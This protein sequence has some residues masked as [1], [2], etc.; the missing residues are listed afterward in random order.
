M[1][2]RMRGQAGECLLCRRLLDGASLDLGLL[3]P[4]NRFGLDAAIPLPRARLHVAACPAC[5][6]IQLDPLPAV[7]D[8]VP[9]LPWIRYNEPD[10][11]LATVVSEIAARVDRARMPVV[12]FGPF[13]PPLL[14]RLAA[15]GFTASYI[16]L[17][18]RARAS[19]P[20]GTFPY[21]ETVQ[22][23][24]A[25]VPLQP[26]ANAEG[27]PRIVVCRYLLE[28][29]HAPRAALERMAALAGP[30]G[31]LVI[32]VPDSTK[33]LAARDYS[34]FWEEHTCYFTPGTLRLMLTGAGLGI[35]ALLSFPGQLDDALVAWV[36][37][38]G[39]ATDGGE[40]GGDAGDGRRLVGGLAAG[41]GAL[42]LAYHD[43]L[44]AL[45]A[46]GRKAALF[47][48]G[49]QAI[50]FLNALELTD[51]FAYVVDDDPTKQG[52]LVP[53]TGTRIVSSAAMLADSAVDVCLV[54][55]SPHV[56][57]RI[58]ARCAL[59]LDRGGKLASI[60]PGSELGTLLD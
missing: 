12:G 26:A 54:A 3:P 31:R 30:D 6:L 41:L 48:A 33:F 37:P 27:T 53:G 4:C 56:E 23:T 20:H 10:H 18:Q 35:D 47:G 5:G 59:L 52:Y 60:Y 39:R 38:G 49:H 51:A 16:D 34:F 8:L 44:R 24:L 42:R 22:A 7:E 40:A 25:Q 55:A 15:A 46:R 9:R 32:E 36:R 21:L 13:D 17:Q 50:M 43:A 57:P 45:S 14:D 1:A 58:R 28:H 19:A 11:H 2:T 29:C